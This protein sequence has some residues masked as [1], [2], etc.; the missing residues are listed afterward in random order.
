MAVGG[1]R[2]SARRRH[3]APPFPPDQVGVAASFA[4]HTGVALELAA[5]RADVERLSLYEDRDRIA[6][7][8]VIQRLYATGMSLQGTMPMVTRPE[9]ASRPTDTRRPSSISGAIRMKCSRLVRRSMPFEL[10]A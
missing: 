6:R 9:I 5:R 1:L 7:D 10:L 8:L 2:A 4:T 3:G